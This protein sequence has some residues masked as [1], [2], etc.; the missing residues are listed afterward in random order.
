VKLKFY[1]LLWS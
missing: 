1:T